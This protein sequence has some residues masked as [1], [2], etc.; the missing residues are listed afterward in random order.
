[1]LVILLIPKS[2]CFQQHIWKEGGSFHT[3]GSAEFHACETFSNDLR[4]ISKK[5]LLMG[6]LLLMGMSDSFNIKVNIKSKNEKK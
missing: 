1:M 6:L 5:V 3:V 4:I 2:K